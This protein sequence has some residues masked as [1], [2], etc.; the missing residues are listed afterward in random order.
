M[1]FGSSSGT[2][3]VNL[4]TLPTACGGWPSGTLWKNGVVVQVCP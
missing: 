4:G 3:I 2:A 1:S